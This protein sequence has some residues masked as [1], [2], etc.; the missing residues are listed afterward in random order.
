MSAGSLL[1][2]HG[3]VARVSYVLLAE[4]TD[5]HLVSVFD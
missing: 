4:W 3:V 1:H 2:L 5:H